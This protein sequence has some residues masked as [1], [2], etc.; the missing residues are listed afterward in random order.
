MLSDG[1]ADY[2]PEAHSTL[3]TKVF[4]SRAHLITTDELRTLV[5]KG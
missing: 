4:P 3:I 5:R 2:D 1:V